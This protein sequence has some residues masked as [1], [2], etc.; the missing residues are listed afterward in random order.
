MESPIQEKP[1]DRELSPAGRALNAALVAA[2]AAVVYVMYD[3]WGN[4]TELTSYG[5]SAFD[6]MRALWASARIYGG[7]SFTLG[8]LIPLLTVALLWRDRNGL[9]AAPTGASWTGF[10]FVLLALSVHWMGLRAQQTRLSLLALV[11]LIWAVVFHLRGWP[12]ARRAAFPISL[13]AF[14]VPLNFLDVFTFPL[15]R[16]AAATA[17]VLASGLG[18]PVQRRGSLIQ[19]LPLQEGAPLPAPLDGAAAA[20]S[21]GVLLVLILIAAFWGAWFRRTPVQRLILAAATP[22]L[23]VTAN[24]LRLL[25]GLLVQAA[26]GEAPG[27][28]L[29]GTGGTFMVYAVS[30]ALLLGLDRLLVSWKNLR[31]WHLLQPTP[32]SIG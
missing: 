22:L 30:I 16:I 10:G 9:R 27:R 7:S 28:A 29:Q 11:F 20:G 19:P 18:L 24:G 13:M 26:A 4:T 23:H 8:W 6:W 17:S 21:L 14:C 32:P 15:Q 31:L 5:Q 3:R 2:C 1:A 25:A 12:T